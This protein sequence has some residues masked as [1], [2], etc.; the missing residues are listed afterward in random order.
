MPM[1]CIFADIAWDITGGID[2]VILGAIR[3]ETGDAGVE[4]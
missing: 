1:T 2:T 4:A 3:S